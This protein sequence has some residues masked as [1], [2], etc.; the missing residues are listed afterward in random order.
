MEGWDHG[1]A[2]TQPSL[3]L[4]ARPE[5]VKDGQK[6]HAEGGS[7]GRRPVILRGIGQALR[8]AQSTPIAPVS[9]TRVCL[10]RN[11]PERGILTPS[12]LAPRCLG[13]HTAAT[14]I[15]QTCVLETL[16]LFKLCDG[17]QGNLGHKIKARTSLPWRSLYSLNAFVVL[18]ANIC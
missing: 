3:C 16:A 4:G 5:R 11:A 18:P 2:K 10:A 1:Q 12:P 14:A 17:H 13:T 15:H 7:A 9:G 6:T 8:G